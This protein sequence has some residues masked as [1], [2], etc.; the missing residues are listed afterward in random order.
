MVKGEEIWEKE[1]DVGIGVRKWRKSYQ[2]NRHFFFFYSHIHLELQFYNTLHS[3][4]LVYRDFF[5]F[6]HCFSSAEKTFLSWD[7]NSDPPCKKPAR[8][9]LS[10]CGTLLSCA[11]PYCVGLKK[12]CLLPMMYI[13]VLYSLRVP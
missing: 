9:Q 7:L 10:F 5:R 3:S 6:L 4:I 1:G 12:Q 8:Y 2:N 13:F 11:A